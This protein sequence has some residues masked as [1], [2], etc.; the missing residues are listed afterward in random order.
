MLTLHVYRGLA[1]MGVLNLAS[2][3]F[4]GSIPSETGFLGALITADMR[5]N[6]FRLDDQMSGTSLG[7]TVAVDSPA[8]LIPC[9]LTLSD[10]TMPRLDGSN[11]ACPALHRKNRDQ[12]LKDCAS[13]LV[14][15]V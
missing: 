9:F 8:N 11:T 7:S 4:T 5:N 13:E 14:S 10:Y 15:S 2:N 6:S 3:R 12:A 1:Q